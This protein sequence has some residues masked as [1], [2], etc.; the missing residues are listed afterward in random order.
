V[1]VDAAALPPSFDVGDLPLD[2]EVLWRLA[3]TVSDQ[4]PIFLDPTVRVA[5]HR[6]GL[7]TLTVDDRYLVGPLPG[8]AGAWVMSGCCVGGL[9]ASPALGEALAEWILDGA[10]RLDLSDISTA[11]FAGTALDERD[12]RERCRRAYASHYRAG[13]ASP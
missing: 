7:P 9:S 3:R 10:P 6:G 1:Q 5:E 11:R 13:A 8:V 12:L 4:F 2:I